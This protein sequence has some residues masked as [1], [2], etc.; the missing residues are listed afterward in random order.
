MKQWNE[1]FKE[2]GLVFLEPKKEII[3]VAE[4]FIR[5]GVKKV[6][7][8]GCG[9]GRHVVYLAKKGFEIYGFD[10]AE[11]GIHLAKS[12]LRKE[13]LKANFSVGSIYER[14]PFKDNFFDAV[15]S[16]HSIHHGRI[17]DV[18]K[19]IREV[20]RVLKQGGFIFINLR[21][22]RI[23]KYDPKNKIIE[24]YG[25]QKVSYKMIAPRTYAPIEGG[26][27]DLL[28]YL[29][30]KK[31]IEKEFRMFRPKI[32]VSESGRHYNLL[33]KKEK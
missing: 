32:W 30:N 1:I 20:Y 28:H 29:F 15:I 17:K 16:T 4:I 14:M 11:E 8:L 13:G 5:N 22:R 2:K 18:R 6:L 21:K 23:R 31:L 9:S 3:K 10:I 19:A 27:K 33:G 24:K 25:A 7:D 12:W 26:E